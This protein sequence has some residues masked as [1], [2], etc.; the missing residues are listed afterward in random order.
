MPRDAIEGTNQLLSG[1]SHLAHPADGATRFSKRIFP[2][3]GAVYSAAGQLCRKK[4]F[5]SLRKNTMPHCK[6]VMVCRKLPADN[7]KFQPITHQ[8]RR[9][10]STWWIQMCTVVDSVNRVEIMPP[11]QPGEI[12][13]RGPQLMREYWN[14][15]EETAKAMRD[16][17]LYR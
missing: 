17:W 8:D 7:F 2:A 12:I 1:C 14:N 15:P 4:L 6:K 16:G 13:F 5:A 11:G 10:G 9:C 3:S